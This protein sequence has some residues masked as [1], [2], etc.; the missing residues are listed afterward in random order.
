MPTAPSSLAP[1]VPSVPVAELRFAAALAALA[2]SA[3][4]LFSAPILLARAAL[5]GLGG[6]PAVWSVALVLL[7]AAL[8]GG[9]LYGL[10]ATRWLAGRRALLLHLALMGAALL[11]LPPHRPAALAR[12]PAEGEAPWLLGLLAVAAGPPLLALAANGLLL[13]AWLS[14]ADHP[15]ARD[16][17]LLAAASHGGAFAALLAYPVLIAPLVSLRAQEWAWTAGFCLLAPLIAAAAWSAA[18]TPP[19]RAP[20]PPPAPA[21]RPVPLTGAALAGF[22][23][24]AFVPAAFLVAVTTRL[25]AELATAPLVFLPPLALHLLTFV[26]A[27]RDSAVRVAR[28]LA[29]LQVGGTALAILGL[30]VD[31]GLAANLVLGL[32]LVLVNASLCHTT[33]YR[34]RPETAHLTIYAVCIALGGLL[35]SAAGALLA[36]ALFPAGQEYPLL[37]GAALLGRPGLLDGARA[38]RARGFGEAALVCALLA[39]L[40]L[41][42]CAVLGLAAPRLLIGLGLC[43]LLALSWASPRLAAL[44]GIG[45]L[46]ALAGPAPAPPGAAG[47]SLRSF[48][49]IHR[50]AASPD[51]GTRLLWH[52]SRPQG[53]MRLRREDGTPAT[54]EPAPLLAYAP[55]GPVGAAI[56]GI[57]AARGGDL[58]DVVVVGLGAGSLACA[59]RPREAW[60]FLESDPVLLRIARDPARFRFLAACAPTM[61]VVVGDPRLSL[62]DRPADLGLILIDTAASGPFPIHLLTREA[63]RLAVSKL[64]RTGVLLIHL[65]H[66][67]L[68]PGAVLA[69]IGAEFGLSAWALGAPGAAS[70]LLALVRDPAHLGP[71]GG[72]ARPGGALLRDAPLRDTLQ[73]DA[74]LRDASPRGTWA[75]NPW[76]GPPEAGGPGWRRVPADPGRRPWTDDHADLLGALRARPG[77]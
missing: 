5:P 48:S 9:Q 52:E 42:G 44:S 37:L 68:D 24:L 28:W 72:R 69:G 45:A 73:G 43:G 60:T 64:D 34:A 59:A 55:D 21:K 22:V 35:G 66:P 54:G 36:P 2:L 4:L 32:G 57:R 18:G 29:P 49:G 33:L 41:A 51:G 1:R 23:A 77:G 3:F 61:P 6:S 11:V 7:Q 67:H 53:A 58:G 12:L 26:T 16:P 39:L 30:V 25:C 8:L 70:T 15:R 75:G 50:I 71:W 65:A 76:P 10:A 46:L 74:L 62:A 20:A 56:R 14:G 40:I 13:Q 19:A 31:L 47:E 38:A 17:A 27:F 63:L